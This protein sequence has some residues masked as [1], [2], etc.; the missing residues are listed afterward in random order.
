MNKPKSYSKEFK[1]KVALEM[2][3]GDL[4]IAEIISKYQVP[5]SV[6]GR[7]K[8]QLLD[9]GASIFKSSNENS[10]SATN[11][12]AEIEKLHATIGKLKVE[13][14]FLHCVSARLKL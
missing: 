12:A 1:F 3:R 2:V 5:R 7:W 8:K 14:D 9:N 4:S 6:L 11:N 10:N 13:N